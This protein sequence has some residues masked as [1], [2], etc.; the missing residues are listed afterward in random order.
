[1]RKS[2]FIILGITLCLVSGLFAGWLQSASIDTWYPRLVKSAFTPPDV[3]FPVAW[4][5]IY[6]CMGVS[7]G[8]VWGG[9]EERGRRATTFLFALQLLLHVLWSVCFFLFR[10]PLLGLVDIIAIDIVAVWYLVR[11]FR[12]NTTSAFLLTPYMAWLM[13]ATYLNAYIV[14]FN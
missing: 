5:I 1:M 12:H 13:L 14:S 10:C 6:I 2:I 9:D 11:M 4:G 3:V 8:L 7:A